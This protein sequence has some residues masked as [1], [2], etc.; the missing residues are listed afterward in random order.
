MLWPDW[1]ILRRLLR[2][3]D[4]HGDVADWVLITTMTVALY[5]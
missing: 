2:L 3:G 1:L 5:T 4:E